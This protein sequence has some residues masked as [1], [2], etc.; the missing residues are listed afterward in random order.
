MLAVQ[1][2][3]QRFV[4]RPLD[5]CAPTADYACMPVSSPAEDGV[6]LVHEAVGMLVR[7][8]AVTVLHEASASLRRSRWLFSTFERLPLQTY[9]VMLVIGDTAKPPDQAHREHDSQAYQR[10]AHKLRRIIAVSEG[11][12]FRIS[13]VRLV[14]NAYA[15]ITGKRQLFAFAQDLPQA[16]EWVQGARSPHT[17]DV[18]QMQ[19]DLARLRQAV[20][21]HPRTS[22]APA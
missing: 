14:M 22:N 12:S 20:S 13:M 18:A 10:V 11:G 21:Q 2:K 3:L 16:F 19:A 7:G 8:D 9:V 17:P 6:P 5:R 4:T 15:L 1:Q